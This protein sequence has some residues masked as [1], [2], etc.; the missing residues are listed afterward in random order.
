[1]RV[2]AVLVLLISMAGPGL[3]QQPCGPVVRGLEGDYF[4]VQ[5]NGGGPRATDQVSIR[6][7]GLEV[8]RGTVMR[9]EGNMCSVRAPGGGVQRMDMVF[10]LDPPGQAEQGPALPNFGS[11]SG[12]LASPPAPSPPPSASSPSS[13]AGK[14]KRDSFF[15]GVGSGGRVLNLNTGEMLTER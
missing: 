2:L 5:C 14:T 12:R 1:M 3:A 15:S 11:G 8:A 7:D 9:V 4:L 13:A 6:R 10:L